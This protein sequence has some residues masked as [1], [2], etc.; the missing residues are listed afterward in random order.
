MGAKSSSGA[1]ELFT[2]VDT[3]HLMGE[4]LA[5]GARPAGERR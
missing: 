5:V 2:R 3:D 4:I 1:R